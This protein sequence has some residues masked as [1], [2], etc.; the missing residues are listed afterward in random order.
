MKK[1]IIYTSL[2]AIALASCTKTQFSTPTYSTGSANFTTFV[3][4]GNSLTQ[5]YM[6]G[7]LYA[8]GQSH[9]YPSIIAQQIGLAT[10]INFNQPMVTGNGSGYIHLV[11]LNGQLTPIQPGDDSTAGPNP[12]DQD[13]SWATWGP[14]L[15]GTSENNLGIAG[16][17]LVNCVALNSTQAII[18]NVVTGYQTNTLLGGTVGN[19]YGRYLNFGSAFT[20]NPTQ[21]INFIR[22]SKATFFTCWLG[23]NDVLGYATSGGVVT[24]ISSPLGNISINDI[25]PPAEFAQDYD[26]ILT[27]FHNLGAKGICATIPDVTSIPFFNT[28]PS[29]VTVNGSRQYLWITTAAGVRQATDGDY[30][31]LTEYTSV[32]AGQ[33]V[34]KSNP[35]PNDEVLDV[36]EV[37][38]VETA[39]LA[40]NASIKS[41]A[42]S[43]G[44]PVIDMYKFLTTLESSIT[45]DGISLSRQFIQGGAF[46]LDG[47]HPTAIG[48]AIIANQFISGIDAAYGATIPPVDVS[49]YRGELFP[50]Y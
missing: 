8:Y 39:T 36:T 35:I 44:Y 50:T 12:C 30:I 37:D 13:P 24:P 27:T 46:G 20:T 15:Y 31:L 19:P 43:M 16:I 40:Y 21:Y 47:V 49:N 33:G 2:V 29:Y 4:V 3:S 25:T 42:G 26:S 17:L 6:D 22:S 18:N 41:I 28:V 9:S 14:S 7:G 23:N 38:S 48:Y 5:G 45:I 32:V 34:Y 10:K 11:Y 1:S